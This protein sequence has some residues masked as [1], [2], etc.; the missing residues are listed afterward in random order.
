MLKWFFKNKRKGFSI[1]DIVICIDD[2]NWNTPNN[3]KK[4]VFNKKYKILSIC[5]LK[6][7]GPSYDIGIRFTCSAFTT[8]IFC[9]KQLPGEYIHWAGHHRF[10]KAT[11][12]EEMEYYKER[13]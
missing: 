1:G 2:R 3:D 10:R 8:C 11:P 4:L 9:S 13:E 5:P 7:H 6:C 12:Q